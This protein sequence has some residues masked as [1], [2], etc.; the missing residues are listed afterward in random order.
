MSVSWLS[1]DLHLEDLK[2]VVLSRFTREQVPLATVKF[3]HANYGRLDRSYLRFSLASKWV[4]A[5][6]H[7]AG[8]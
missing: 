8:L 6:L 1:L 5:S 2:Y 7:M 3:W 4:F